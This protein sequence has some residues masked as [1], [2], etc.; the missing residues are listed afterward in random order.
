ME[1]LNEI[2]MN[3]STWFQENV[4]VPEVLGQLAVFLGLALAAQ[5]LAK[6]TNKKLTALA[7]DNKTFSKFEDFIDPLYFPMI[8][9][10]FLF[11][12]RTAAI[13]FEFPVKVIEGAG[14]LTVAWIGVRLFT[15][16]IRSQR[17]ARVLSVFV[18]SIAALKISNLLGPL[19]EVLQGFAL[20][21]GETRVSAYDVIWGFL[22][23]IIFIWVGLAISRLIDSQLKS[24]R[25]V[26]PS[27]KVLLGKISKITLITFAFLIAMNTMGIDL[28]AL[29]V[30]GGALGVGLGFGLQKVV[31]NFISGVIL[32]MDRSIKP[33]D[34]IQ[35]QDT[36]GS[37]NKLAARYTSV[38]TRDGTEYL[39]PNEDMIT[40]PVINW[41]HTNRVV[42]R[43]IPLSV[44]YKTDLN[45]AM[46]IM[47][48]VAIDNERVLEDPKPKTLLKGF[49]D[50][51]VELELRMWINNPEDG[52]SN[53]GS[54]VMMEIWNR[55][56]AAGVNFP[57]PQRVI[58][59]AED[60][61]AK[62][63]IVRKK[64]KS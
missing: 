43:R 14:T 45:E 28:T 34:V 50:N 26:N 17:T 63:K 13:L 21:F 29:A 19:I 33:G 20:T 61:S 52:V 38:I 31:S 58:H 53:I 55:F 4:L 35:I 16:F 57:F 9:L 23:L 54:E 42:R 7:T 32:L 51:G 6:I 39:I 41:S 12:T 18:V 5:F 10:I 56:H 27:V 64:K 25:S 40:Q 24:T 60:V 62:R 47:T 2:A 48:Q 22:T 3:V 46:E 49:G 59:F 15:R 30:F 11:L 37:I 44:D 36:Y 8:L 1:N